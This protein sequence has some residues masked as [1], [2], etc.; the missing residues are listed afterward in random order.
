MFTLDTYSI[1]FFPIF[2][3]SSLSFS[4]SYIF[5]L[6]YFFIPSFIFLPFSLFTHSFAPVYHSQFFLS[7]FRLVTC[8]PIARS[9]L[10]LTLPL[11]L[12]PIFRRVFNRPWAALQLICR[13]P[14]AVCSPFDR[15]SDSPTVRNGV[16]FPV[17]TDTLPHPSVHYSAIVALASND[18][19]LYPRGAGDLDRGSDMDAFFDVLSKGEGV[20]P[21]WT[22]APSRSRRGRTCAES[23]V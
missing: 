21:R 18:P 17:N 22:R 20:K 23:I 11:S 2:S 19:Y 6:L 8:T 12:S 7:C 1:T 13:L 15:P 5:L 9:I 3:F 4:L 14:L 10:Q 16:R